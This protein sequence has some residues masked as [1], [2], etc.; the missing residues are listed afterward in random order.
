MFSGRTNWKRCE[1]RYTQALRRHREGGGLLLDLTVSNP[2]ACGFHYDQT[3]ILGALASP[4]SMHYDP[5]P[6]LKPGLVSHYLCIEHHLRE[7]A[8]IYDFMAGDARYKASL[9]EP[10]PEMLHLVIQR[11]TVTLQTELV[12]RQANHGLD[13]FRRKARPWRLG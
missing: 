12:L 3:A 7:G 9:G 13:H 5:D 6:K 11:P 1:N 8:R 10:G 4:A 2:T